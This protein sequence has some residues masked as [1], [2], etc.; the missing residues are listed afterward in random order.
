MSDFFDAIPEVIPEVQGPVVP[1]RAMDERT[2]RREA[3]ALRARARPRLPGTVR[4]RERLAARDDVIGRTVLLQHCPHCDHIIL[5][6][7]PV[8][9]GVQISEIQPLRQA[10]LDPRNVRTRRSVQLY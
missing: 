1:A 9:P 4:P 7:A 5:R 2:L 8:A 3:R 10:K 6:V